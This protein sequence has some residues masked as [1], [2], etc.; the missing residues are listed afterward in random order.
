M[1]YFF[2]CGHGRLTN[3]TFRPRKHQTVVFFSLPG[4]KTYL[5]AGT[6][7]LFDSN[8]LTDP[9][10]HKGKRDYYNHEKEY[11]SQFSEKDC[12]DHPICHLKGD[13]T[14]S[15]KRKCYPKIKYKESPL[16]LL[17][18]KGVKSKCKKDY[19]CK[20]CDQ[21]SKDYHYNIS[22]WDHERIQT[23]GLEIPDLDI[24]FSPIINEPNKIYKYGIY[25]LPN[26]QLYSFKEKYGSYATLKEFKKN[27]GY[28][29]HDTI[30]NNPYLK[31][32][33]I[34][35]IFLGSEQYSEYP[36]NKEEL[37]NKT[38]RLSELLRDSPDGVYFVLSC[39]SSDYTLQF[40]YYNLTEDFLYFNSENK[41]YKAENKSQVAILNN[42]DIYTIN[43]DN[44]NIHL[45]NHLDIL[46]Y[47]NEIIESKNVY[48]HKIG[49]Y[50]Y[51]LGKIT[52]IH[53][54]SET[55]RE[56]SYT[57]KITNQLETY[58]PGKIDRF[59]YLYNFIRSY[60]PILSYSIGE[61]DDSLVTSK[62]MQYVYIL[63]DDN[64][65][66]KKNFMSKNVWEKVRVLLFIPNI[67]DKQ[68]FQRMDS[69]WNLF[70]YGRQHYL[71][72]VH[73][74]SKNDEEKVFVK[75]QLDKYKI[76][77]D[78]Q[79]P[80]KILFNPKH[81]LG[82]NGTDEFQFPR[83]KY[84][85][86]DERNIDY[87]SFLK[88][89]QQF[90]N[91]GNI[92]SSIDIQTSDII[93]AT[94]NQNELDDLMDDIYKSY[95]EKGKKIPIHIRQGH[96]MKKVQKILKENSSLDFSA[97][98]SYNAY[99]K[100]L[101]RNN[102]NAES[103]INLLAYPFFYRDEYKKESFRP[104]TRLAVYCNENGIFPSNFN[105]IQQWNTLSKFR[106]FTHL[107]TIGTV[108]TNNI[109]KLD[110]SNIELD[111]T[112]FI[113]VL[114]NNQRKHNVLVSFIRLP[115]ASN[116]SIG[117]TIWI[118]KNEF[119]GKPVVFM[120]KE[121]DKEPFEEHII[122]GTNIRGMTDPPTIFYRLNVRNTETKVNSVFD[123]L[124]GNFL[125]DDDISKQF[126]PSTRLKRSNSI[127]RRII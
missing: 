118:R 76:N 86:G 98:Y 64:Q 44:C 9:C 36:G 2:L 125:F 1:D 28:S 72:K 116:L 121:L 101:T 107:A 108:L 61:T 126:S 77:H 87:S 70:Y 66:Y 5:E 117:N 62:E 52:D 123:V 60:Y 42:N 15:K 127:S 6:Q 30:S 32:D 69:T 11:C 54:R 57:I 20:M 67:L 27:N 47:Y 74:L 40:N 38:T 105:L 8:I 16:E 53:Y 48:E 49:D 29:R 55:S 83:W 91:F 68:Y 96:I 23:S 45:L 26:Q 39:R 14:K 56:G 17:S 75:V 73:F 93:N 79:L 46:V 90:T 89:L 33:I 120:E 65:N 109:L 104:G 31:T 41:L 81:F 51:D 78:T 102:S 94:K 37:I 58:L 111:L 110:H 95:E 103:L 12:N 34:D 19:I 82:N 71:A 114:I 35:E 84:T 22:I 63:R 122:T 13:P 115:Y 85:L 112:R 99:Y 24:V 88:Y 124:Q 80:I 100:I 119:Y 59:L 21:L 50:Y 25:R 92:L 10:I 97:L 18:S 3:T 7:L 113:E 106:D 43:N 4:D